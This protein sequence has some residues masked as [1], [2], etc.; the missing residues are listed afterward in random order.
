VLLDKGSVQGSGSI[1]QVLVSHDGARILGDEAGVV[2]VGEIAEQD[3]QNQSVRVRFS[4]G[5]V[6]VPDYTFSVGQTVRLRILARDVSLSLTK[7]EDST[8]QNCLQGVIEAIEPD[9][10]ASQTLLRVRCGQE[11]ILSRVSQQSLS[12][13]GLAVGSSVWCQI[14]SILLLV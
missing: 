3:V 7:H 10:S 14:K 2:T 11:M 8:I 9:V 6:W 4:G 12:R 1:S 13:L 5:N